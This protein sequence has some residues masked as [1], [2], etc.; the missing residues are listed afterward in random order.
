MRLFIS[1]LFVLFTS[2]GFSQSGQSEYLEAK[3]QFS[4]G[5]YSEAQ[6]FFQSLTENP[7]FGPYASFYYALSALKQGDK[8]VAADWWK[9]TLLKYPN[10]DQRNE[11]NYWLGYVAFSQKKY[12]E[13][14]N[15]LEN[16][17][18]EMRIP[19]IENEF[20]KRSYEELKEAYM[21]NPSNQVIAGYFAKS[22]MS[23]PSVQRDH[24][25][26]LELSDKFDIPIDTEE[27]NL[28]IIKKDKY[29]IAVVLPFMFNSLDN[30]Q[31]VIGNTIIFDMY[32]G[33]L[34]AQKTLTTEGIDVEIFPFDTQKKAN[35]TKEII[36]SGNFKN[37]DVIIGPLYGGPNWEVS[38]F[39]RKEKITMINPLS[40]NEAIIGDNPYSYLFKS[41]YN[42]QG[43]IAASYAKKEFGDNKKVLIF[44]ETNR[45]SLIASAYKDAIQQDS[46]FVVRFERITNKSAQQVQKDF[47]E[48]HKVRL[49]K[50][51]SQ[52]E[53]DSIMLTGRYITT[54]S[55]RGENGEETLVCYENQFTI[56]EDSIG[57][58]FPA[59]NSNLLANNFI[60]LAEVRRDTIGIIGYEDWLDFSLVSFNQLERLGISLIS[61]G[62]FQTDT[63]SY[64]QL[65]NEFIKSIGKEPGEYHIIGYE[66]I[67]QIG[68]LLHRHGKYFQRGLLNEQHIPG[69][70]MDG[71][72]YGSYHDNQV[73]P[74]VKLENLRLKKQMVLRHDEN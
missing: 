67:I 55:V 72:R 64:E 65:K 66:L 59:T 20:S 5:N 4:L 51:Y 54:R 50:C 53:I 69:L 44:F 56:L 35:K 21:L 9:Q 2:F 13:A 29:A 14:F 70:Y 68:R 15:Y 57:H 48:Q 40:S 7:I 24:Q 31:S 23:K 58:I 30:P 17:P 47:I 36:S 45:D 46:F 52:E 49:D 43:R 28:P 8:K 39:S 42:T 33:M 37:A 34:M 62:F 73:V 60:N 41:S 25:M 61:P 3:K 1:T 38:N 63:E 18:E 26:L 12:G 22:I 32:Q 27:I 6:S 16:L 10:W 11:V 74:I 19:L 71:L